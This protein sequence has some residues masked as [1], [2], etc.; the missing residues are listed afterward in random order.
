MAAD[1]APTTEAHETDRLNGGRFTSEIEADIH[2]EPTPNGRK[3]QTE[4]DD[5]AQFPTSAEADSPLVKTDATSLSDSES[6]EPKSIPATEIEPSSALSTASAEAH[7][8]N[9][10]SPPP[11]PGASVAA[12]TLIIPNEETAAFSLTPEVIARNARQA[13]VRPFQDQHGTPFAWLPVGNGE[14]RHHECLRIRSANFRS[15]LLEL[16]SRLTET[17]PK[18]SAVKQAIEILELEAYR[19]T[20]ETLDNRSAADD[21]DVFIDL[22][23]DGWRM[24][25]ITRDGWQVIRHDKPRFFRPQHMQSLPEPEYG[26]DLNELFA[27][28]PVENDDEKLLLTVWLLGAMYPAIPKPILLI[29]GPQGS[30]KTTRSRRL[31]SLLD[32]SVTPVLGDLEKSNLFLTFRNHAV[33]CFENVSHFSRRE[34]DMFCRAV[35]GNGV[36]RRKLFTD[37]DQVLYTFRRPILIN[38]IDTPTTRPDFLDRC[39]IYN[40]R[41]M[42]QFAPLEELDRQ[43]EAARP[44]LFGSMLDVL[45]KTL[46]VL[47]STPPAKE[48]RMA[49]FAR[50]GRAVAVALGK[51]PEDFDNAYRMNVQQQRFDVLEDVPMVRLLKRFAAGYP[52]ETKWVGTAESLLDKLSVLAKGHDDVEGKRNLPKSARWLSS[53]LGELAPALAMDGVIVTKLPRSNA[54]RLWELHTV[55]AEATSDVVEAVRQRMEGGANHE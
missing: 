52:V 24:V 33:P 11:E 12:I 15:R 2:R 34:A 38:G 23:D 46:R 25:R 49:D 5:N 53:R 29:V 3:P 18:M 14:M 16:S 26:G 19:S 36:E 32:P 1:Q 47:N 35:T 4:T 8:E 48:F 9:P 27:F 13:G 28:V 6:T 43:F 51:R 17:A 45:V 10:V 31:R 30:A 21:D 20:K 44:K 39:L 42:D 54:R 7:S 22:G 50:F 37:G 55:T 41:R 40:C